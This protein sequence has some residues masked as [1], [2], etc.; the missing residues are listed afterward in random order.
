V[1]ANAAVVAAAADTAAVVVV[2][3][4][5]TAAA[6]ADAAAEVVAAEGEAAE[7]AAAVAVVIATDANR[8]PGLWP[9]T[10]TFFDWFPSAP[11]EPSS[12]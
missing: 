10:R 5:D 2:A 1:A 3:A 9:A 7:V 8:G 11:W 12:S 4:A 6:V